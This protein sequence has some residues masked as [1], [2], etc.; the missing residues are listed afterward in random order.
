MTIRFSGL[1]GAAALFA[2]SGS[3]LAQQFVN[4]DFSSGDLSG[5]TITTTPNGR[6][7]VQTVEEF[8][9][10][11]PGPL[12]PS[13]AGKFSVG[14]ITFVF[15]QQDGINLVQELQLTGGVEYRFSF[16]WAAFHTG[17]SP[18]A[19]GGVFSL[20]VNDALLE[21]QAAGDTGPGEPRYGSITALFTPPATG[22]YT[23]GARIT[24]P[25]NVPGG[26]SQ[27]VDNFVVTPGTAGCYANCDDSTVEPVLN[28]DDFT[29]FINEYASAQGLPYE[30]QVDHYANCD[31]S[32][33]APVLNVDDFTCFINQYAQGCR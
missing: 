6:T 25:Y 18:N 8:D 30:Q 4:G 26:L 31:R 32:T 24:R 33:I 23:V 16:D 17:T 12:E 7:A 9:I 10:D 21:T 27:Y 19:E 14:S 13:L 29:C 1:A 15:N 11:G 28:V 3:A 2:L 22:P 20:I 5:W